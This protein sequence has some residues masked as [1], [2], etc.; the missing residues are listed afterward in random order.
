MNKSRTYC[1]VQRGC[2]TFR[3]WQKWC[4]RERWTSFENPVRS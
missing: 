4:Q 3:V 1:R 2:A